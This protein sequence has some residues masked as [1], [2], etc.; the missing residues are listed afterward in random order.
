M[1]KKIR[2]LIKQDRKKLIMFIV[3]ASFIVS[4]ILTGTI[5]TIRNVIINRKP[6]ELKELSYKIYTIDGFKCRTLVT[7]YNENGIDTILCQ[8]DNNN[9]LRCNGKKKVAMDLYLEDRHNYQFHV[10]YANNEEKDLVLNFEIPRIHGK[11]TLKNGVYANE[12]DV[13]TGFLPDRTRY[14][15][16]NDSGNLVPGNWIV[17]AEPSNWYD[18]KNK[19][20][21]NIYVESEGVDSYYVWIP[22]YCYKIGDTSIVGNE[23]MDVKF[24]NVYN[25]YID[26]N[27]GVTTSWEEL[28]SQGYQI[29]EAFSWD[30]QFKNENLATDIDCIYD[31]PGYW[32]S[33]YQLSELSSYALDY[34][35][36]PDYNSIEIR[37]IAVNSTRTASRYIFA[38]DGVQ[39]AS[40]TNISNGYTFQ[41]VPSGD[42]TINV[43][44]LDSNG[45]IVGS[46]TRVFEV[47]YPNEPDLSAFD[48]DTTFYVYWDEQKNEHNEIPIS[49][50]APEKWYDYTYARWANIVTRND[51]MET[52]YVWIPR[53]EYQLNNVNQRT[54]VRFLEGTTTNV[55]SG[56]QIPEAFWWDNNGNGKQDS[57][58]QIPGYWMTKYQLSQ[59][60]NEPRM[61]AEM[62][63]GS[64][65]IR[66]KDITGTLITN[67]QNN[68]VAVK[69]EYY[70]NGDLITTGTSSTQHYV[71]EGLEEN[72]TYIV[73]IIARNKNTNE[74]IGAVTKKI[75]TI[76]PYA[77]DVSS[78][79]KNT[80]YYVVYNGNNETRVSI[81]NDP[82]SN[83][84][85]YSNQQW[86]NIVT[87]ANNTETYFVWIPRYEYKIL[88][89]RP[90]LSTA[91]RRIDVNFITTDINNSNC[92]P[93]Y[94]V[95]E[96]FW[97]DNNSNGIETSE[98]RLKGY[99]MS[100]YQLSNN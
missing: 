62:S 61:N 68:G 8:D 22:R 20:W 94:A 42:K 45:E 88:T 75:K 72:K 80:T 16:L 10:K 70:L 71:Y 47:S 100:K 17:G 30:A 9:E 97:W 7:F 82:P 27:T 37:N 87:T 4:L 15:Y 99:W 69:Y 38:I 24:I 3:L 41:N 28:E 73:N 13:S 12:P 23:R 65:L 64:N 35:S 51:G 11:Y 85:D 92:T 14:M 84:Y 36:V 44:A 86:A 1:L 55:D 57:G 34:V 90:N 32:M 56:Y 40:L 66:I 83:W 79:D 5:V 52:Y 49:K 25:E 98:E 59:E 31:M 46:M 39:V 26:A 33:K 96:A 76:A 54:Y 50:A 60:E 53:Y 93:G 43:T 2:S 78:F 77:P 91:N 74:Y 19:K 63:A 21:A 58:E 48:Q 95:P 29:P 6:E 89:D 18:Y 67:A 81:N